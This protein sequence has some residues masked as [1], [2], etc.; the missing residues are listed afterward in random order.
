MLE[1]LSIRAVRNAYW[2]HVGNG[3]WRSPVEAR[4]FKS[5][6]VKAG[7]PDLFI[8][9]NGKPYGLELKTE[10]GKLTPV[11]RAAHVLL[12]AAGAEV[13][14]AYGLDQALD[15]LERWGLAARHRIAVLDRVTSPHG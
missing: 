5:L 10:R 8:V 6:G 14:T 13:A 11:Q 3:G 7:V 2:F 15:Q 12:Q 1:H 4:I 9:A